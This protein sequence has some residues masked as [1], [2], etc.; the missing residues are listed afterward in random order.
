MAKR[1]KLLVH[2]AVALVGG[3]CISQPSAPS[4]MQNDR[5]TYSRPAKCKDMTA[6]GTC[7]PNAC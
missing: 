5:G 2:S 7:P 4:N 1:E 6:L 3:R